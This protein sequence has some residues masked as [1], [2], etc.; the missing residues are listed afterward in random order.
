M[1]TIQKGSSG[2]EVEVW[3]R[4]LAASP[5]PT[6]W[7]NAAGKDRTW[8][9]EWGWPPTI[10]GI[11]GDRT[12][13]ATEAWQAGRGLVADG[14]VGPK[15]WNAAGAL[16]EASPPA[17]PPSTD[18]GKFDFIQAKNFTRGRQAAIRLLVVHTME[19]Q[20]IKRSARNVAGWFANQPKRGELLDGKP[21]GGSSAHYNVDRDEIVQSVQDGD[22]AWHANAVNAYS[23]GLEHA[24][25][26]KQTAEDWKDDYS[27]AMLLRS[28]ALAA[29]LCVRYDIPV[30]KLSVAD[31]K[32]GKRGFCGHV[33][34]TEAFGPP[35]GHRDPGTSFPWDAYLAEVAARIAAVTGGPV[36]RAFPPEAPNWVPLRH[37]GVDWLVS[38]T[39]VA[40][41]GIGEAVSLAK[42]MGCEL[43]TPALVDAIWNAADLKLDALAL[44]Q[45]NFVEWSQAEM[46]SEAVLADQQARVANQIGDRKFTLLGGSHKDVVR[47]P[48]GRIGL[49]GWHRSDVPAGT[50]KPL[51]PFYAGHAA[52]W[53]DYSQGLR[54]VK[55]AGGNS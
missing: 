18:L 40:P 16:T 19:N 21:W 29:Q 38:S 7:T 15:T 27:R 26:A 32:A 47:H 49:Y 55:R 14:I 42:Q 52:S 34:S 51:Q 1:K 11:F 43:P 31:L 4:V 39:Y 20:E 50:L 10:D 6:E 13:A 25:F 44:R 54:L 28:A 36:T 12:Q 41:V 45:T 37:A 17:D 2:N 23:I 9:V 46:S 30:V 22:T 48:D 8:A 35:G 5:A 33:D 3:Q 53:K 24:G